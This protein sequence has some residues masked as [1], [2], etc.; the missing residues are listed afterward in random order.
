M[1]PSLKPEDDEPEALAATGTDGRRISKDF[2]LR[3]PHSGD[4]SSRKPT[5]TDAMTDL[6]INP[7][8]IRLALEKKASDASRRVQTG[9]GVEEAPPG[10]EPGMKVLQTSALPLGYGARKQ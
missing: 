2:P 3:V 8:G 1:L 9:R 6:D 5:E 10:F 4:R 7:S